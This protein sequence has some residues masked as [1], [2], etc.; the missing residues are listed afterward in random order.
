MIIIEIRA[1]Y[2][3]FWRA[4]QTSCSQGASFELNHPGWYFFED[5]IIS[6]TVNKN[7]SNK[8]NKYQHIVTGVIFAKIK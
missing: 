6:C 8:Q 5:D 1:S 4:D 7:L 3:M 2:E